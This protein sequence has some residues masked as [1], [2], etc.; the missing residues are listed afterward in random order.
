MKKIMMLFCLILI[1]VLLFPVNA[2]YS[3]SKLKEM[4]S[5]MKSQKRMHSLSGKVVESM[6]SRG[7]TYISIEKDGKK[8]WVAVPE[9]K[10]LVG[11]EIS[12]RPGMV[13]NN[14][15]SK[16][17]NRTFKTIVFSGGTIGQKG[18]EYTKKTAH[19][20]QQKVAAKMKIKIEKA[21]G[22][23]AYTVAELYEKSA[24]LD[25]RDIVIKGRVV[26]VSPNIMGKNWIHIQDG[27]GNPSKGNDDIIVTSQDLFSVGDVVTV[28]GRL[29][30]DKDFGSGYKYAVIVEQATIKK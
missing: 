23:D 5:G 6:N 25:K 28:R 16:T 20:M 15:E 24:E 30:R 17:L 11:Q 9:M 18:V 21:S 10:V 8:S 7:Y 13:M 2:I 14:F 4:D 1:P 3:A 22:S 29:Y 12:F 26:K 19:H 27:S